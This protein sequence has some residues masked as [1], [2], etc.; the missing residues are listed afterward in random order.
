M[1]TKSSGI[2]YIKYRVTFVTNQIY[3][4]FL[5]V[6]TRITSSTKRSINETEKLSHK[7]KSL[8]A[9]ANDF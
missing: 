5:V 1:Y 4:Y 3:T 8:S 7:K 2:L 9:R 6:K